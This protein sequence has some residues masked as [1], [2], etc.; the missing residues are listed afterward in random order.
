MIVVTGG[1]GFIG[2]CFVRKLND[3]GIKDILIVDNLSTSEKWKNLRG[4]KFTDYSHKSNFRNQLL[5]GDYDGNIDA[6]FHF[7]ACSATT[8]RDVDYLM[9]NN[10]SYSKDIALYCAEKDIDMIYAS[11]A[12]TYGD[13]A[14]GYS[15]KD[16]DSLL[17][18]NA[19]GYSK[20]I[21][22][23]WLI[24]NQLVNKFAGIKY[25]NVFGPNEYHKGDMASMSYKSYN[26]VVQIGKVRLFRSNDERFGDG[27]Q[28]RDFIYVKDC[29]NI[30]WMI[31]KNPSVRGIF[32][33]G[34]G[35]SRTWNDLANSVFMALG[36]EPKIEFIEMPGSLSKQYQNYTEADVSKL[37]SALPGVKFTSLEESVAD[38]VQNYLKS[39]F[40]HY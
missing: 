14:N 23:L 15:D 21:F 32:N 37:V 10:Y 8:E 31:Y 34:T 4:K 40:L 27:E 29:V 17:P 39:G 5:S 33:L 7:G 24:E 1:A 3:E 36:L 22:D 6:V 18:L 12:A 16:F 25:F 20:H 28:K 30:L 38:Y 19:Y 13:G 11:S 35:Q 9:D 26:Q 2:S